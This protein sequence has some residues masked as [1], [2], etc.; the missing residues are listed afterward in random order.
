VIADVLRPELMNYLAA[1]C[2]TQSLPVFHRF[3]AAFFATSRRCS[4]VN[5]S[6]L[7]FPPFSPPLLANSCAGVGGVGCVST[8]SPLARSTISR[9]SWFGS[10][11][12]LGVRVRHVVAVRYQQ[13]SDIIEFDERSDRLQF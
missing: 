6:A 9:A 11:G 3:A 5:D 13:L 2:A 12:R 8:I 4:A 1:C 7:A 10:R